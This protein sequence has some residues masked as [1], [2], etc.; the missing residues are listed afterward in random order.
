MI[1]N[2]Y[3]ESNTGKTLLIEKLIGALKEKGYGVGT[4]KNIKKEDFTIDIEGK[5]TWR[6]SKAGSKVVVAKSKSEVAFLV[7]DGMRPEE[8]IDVMKNIAG[9]DIIIVEGYW[10]YEGPKVA[11]GEIEERP[12]MVIRYKDDFNEIL[13]YTIEGI[14]VEYLKKK[15]PGLDCGKCG[16][17]TCKELALSIRMKKNEFDDCY[18]FSEKRVSM[19]VDGKEIPLGKFAKDIVAGTIEGMV[20]SLKGVEEAKDITIEIKG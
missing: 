7:N 17:E 20:S 13:D 12:G 16:M 6:H 11:V 1:L 9:L 5:D 15:L 4:V 10:D 3:G 19:A 18:Y 2:T 14:E 8:V